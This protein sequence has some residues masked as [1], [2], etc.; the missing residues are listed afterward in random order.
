MAQS[1]SVEAALRAMRT[2]ATRVDVQ[3]GAFSYL[4]NTVIEHDENV[5]LLL[6]CP[7]LLPTLFATRDLHSGEAKLMD[8]MH[9]VCCQL[10]RL[11][12]G[13]HIAPQTVKEPFTLA[14]LVARSVADSTLAEL[15]IRDPADLNDYLV[16]QCGTL[17]RSAR[18]CEREGCT[19]MYVTHHN[20]VI[21]PLHNNQ[22]QLM[23]CCSRRCVDK[24]ILACTESGSGEVTTELAQDQ[25]ADQL[26]A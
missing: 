3:S 2:H 5:R 13:S 8:K 25:G 22:W 23:R 11:T 14:E 18:P 12:G 21:R 26:A 7:D 24:V 15:G 4:Y 1:G 16:D 6:A 9:V 20:V 17:V 19:R 10:A